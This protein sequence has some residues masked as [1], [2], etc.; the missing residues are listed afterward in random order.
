MKGLALPAPFNVQENSGAATSLPVSFNIS[1][2]AAES[3]ETSF[4]VALALLHMKSGSCR[5]LRTL[6]NYLYHPLSIGSRPLS[7]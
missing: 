7:V 5:F 2:A 1:C 3:P 4:A 6:V